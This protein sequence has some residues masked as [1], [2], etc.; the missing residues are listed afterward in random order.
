MFN[1]P[2]VD[3]FV[4]RALEAGGSLMQAPTSLPEFK[5]SFAFVRDNEGHVVEAL[6]RHA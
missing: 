6:Q 2:D 5:L 4:A 1:T 3:A